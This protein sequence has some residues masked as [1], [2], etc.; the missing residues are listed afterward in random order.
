MSMVLMTAN[1]LWR[2]IQHRVML[3][4]PSQLRIEG[5][6]S[7]SG[8]L[9][10]RFLNRVAVTDSKGLPAAPSSLFYPAVVH[11][12]RGDSLMYA[13]LPFFPSG[14]NSVPHHWCP[15]HQLNSSTNI[16]VRGLRKCYVEKL[17]R[18]ERPRPMKIEF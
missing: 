18:K 2:D 6:T 9:L 5:C 3:Y 16:N 12:F 1:H 7:G 11:I 17:N 10:N 15:P 14:R 13:L 8:H 4:E